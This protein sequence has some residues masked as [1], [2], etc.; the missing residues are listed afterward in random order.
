MNARLPRARKAASRAVRRSRADG[1]LRA[2]IDRVHARDR[3]RP[4]RR[5]SASSATRMVV[6]ARRLRRRPRRARLHAPLPPRGRERLARSADDARRQR[7]LAR[8]VHRWR[9]SAA[10]AT[11]SPR[12]STTS[13]RGAHEFKRRVD[14][15]DIASAA[16]VGAK[17]IAEAANRAARGDAQRCAQWGKQLVAAKD[18]DEIK[19]IALDEELAALAQRYPDRRFAAVYER[20]LDG[21]R[22]SAARALLELVRALSALD[23]RRARTARHVSRRRGA[24]RLRRASSA[25][26][27]SICRR[28]IP[29]GRDKRKGKNNALDA[30]AGRRRQ[31]VGDRLRRRRP[32][33]DP[34][35][36]RHAGRLQAPRRAARASSASRSRSTSRSSAR[37]ITRTS[38]E[39]PEWFT[40]A[41]RRHRAVRGESAEE[42]PG[43]LPVQLRVRGLEGAVG[44]AEE[45]LR[46]LDRSRA[47]PS[48]AS[49]TRTPSRF[50]SGSG[51]SSELKAAASRAH[52]PRGSVHAAEDHAPAGQ[53]RLH[54][55]VH[56]LRVAQ[57][58]ARADRVL[59]RARARAGPRVLPAR[60]CGR[61]RRTS[62]PSI[63]QHGGRPAFCARLLL[64]ATLGGELRHLRAGVRADRA[65]AARTRQRRVSRTP[66]STRSARGTSS[67]PTA[68]AISS[69]A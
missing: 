56:L 10:I 20:E 35:R 69:R 42:V 49:T 30:G 65:R 21:R 53:A 58:E 67:A 3:R 46:V 61:T 64:A 4:L 54:A 32:Q 11:P 39:H 18:P 33:G 41:S 24:A 9:S 34:S 38:K 13:C 31:P 62:S 47:S 28:S 59:H 52:L 25:S 12:G 44:R 48:S 63:L 8:R 23:E 66:R 14:P 26:T 36:A 57:H 45:R 1:A 60:T 43:H 7:P 5:R 55:V 19:R 29:I 16:L 15:A 40:L 6:E 17:L 2:V 37:P 27:S 68:C 51:R 50:R 22:R